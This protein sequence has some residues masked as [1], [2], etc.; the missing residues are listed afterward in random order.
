[1]EQTERNIYMSTQSKNEVQ[2]CEMQRHKSSWF[3]MTPVGLE[4]LDIPLGRMKSA[5][6]FARSE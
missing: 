1:M 2:V 4:D 6:C 5:L 3:G